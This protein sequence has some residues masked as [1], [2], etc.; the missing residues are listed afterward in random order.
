MK[1]L[2]TVFLIIILLL[3]IFSK[4]FYNNAYFSVNNK[5]KELNVIFAGTC[6]N[7]EKYIEKMLRHIDKCGNKF[8]NYKLIIYENDST[9][10]TRNL[11][12]KN[13]KDN[14]I[15]LF[16]DN[17]KEPLR[18][19]RLADG[20]N[21]ILDKVREITKNNDYQYL[22]MIDLDDI[23][24]SGTFVN[25]IKTNFMYNKWDVMTSCQRNSYYDIWALRLKKL[26]YFDIWKQRELSNDKKKYDILFKSVTGKN[27]SKNVFKN[28]FSRE[29]IEVDSAFCGIALYKLS[30]IPLKCKYNGLHKNG[31]EKCEHVD[32]N[33]CIKN[34]GGKIYINPKFYTDGRLKTPIF[35]GILYGLCLYI[36][37]QLVYLIR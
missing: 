9:D 3:L 18:T 7:I 8:K 24:A 6:K 30:S 19:K 28:N 16:E 32:F 29:L 22:I 1:Y 26:I 15:Y 35:I 10:S 20:R 12:I 14:Y 27:I 23:N 33:R 5:T 34:N 17:I 37:L 11:L 4:I 25:T 36:L 21:K 13:K 31:M 2:N